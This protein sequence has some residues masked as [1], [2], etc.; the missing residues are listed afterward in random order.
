MLFK[1]CFFDLMLFC[2]F[3][4]G[5][6][7]TAIKIYEFRTS[8]GAIINFDPAVIRMSSLVAHIEDN[9]DIEILPNL[10]NMPGIIPRV[11]ANR[12]HIP[13]FS[14]QIIKKI[15]EYVTYHKNDAEMTQQKM[16]EAK[17]SDW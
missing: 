15:S 17:I 10:Q 14:G 12:Y 8:D 7:L 5:F 2:Q 4:I 6:A 1:S 11:S 3:L 13:G 9:S 16:R